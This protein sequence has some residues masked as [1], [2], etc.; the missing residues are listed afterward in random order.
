MGENV[1]YGKERMFLGFRDMAF[2]WN[3]DVS[4]QMRFDRYE[5]L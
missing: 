1:D 5:I 4:V 3:G 2:N